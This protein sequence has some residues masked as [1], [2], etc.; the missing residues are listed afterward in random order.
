[1]QLSSN[2]LAVIL[3]F[4]ICSLLITF[5]RNVIGLQTFGV[6][7]P[8]LVA[9]T[10]LYTGLIVGIT[11]LA[12]ILIVAW[13]CH[14]IL[15]K[16]RILKT[17]RL[18]IVVSLISILF[19]LLLWHSAIDQKMEFGMLA[20]MPVVI[21]SFV[22]ERIHQVT[23]DQNWNELFKNIAGSLIAIS[24]CYV[25]LNSHLLQSIFTFYPECYLLVIAGLIMIGQWEGIR[26]SEVIRFKHIPASKRHNLLGI[27]NRNRNIVYKHNDK[28]LLRLAMNKI[29]SK[30][31]L[32][33]YDV[34]VPETL[35]IIRNQMDLFCLF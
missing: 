18:A 22:A 35:L 16:L 13:L 23:Q 30:R 21:I 26:S 11:G 3:L 8:V 17:A 31:C 27:N 24:L 6:F 25:Y 19:I 2:T 5:L 29:E 9:A 4:P 15:E 7:M 34:P 1:M 32:K 33:L 12:L 20:L 10:C 28:K 14:H